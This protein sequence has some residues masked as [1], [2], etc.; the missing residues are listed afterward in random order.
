MP[1]DL[2][3]LIVTA[4]LAVIAVGAAVVA[5]RSV[6]QLRRELNKTA[7]RPIAPSE[8]TEPRP[9]GSEVV[10]YDPVSE[11]PRGLNQ[12]ARLVDGRVVV[13]PTRSQVANAVM[14]QPRVRIAVWA[15]GLAHALR[16]ESR[17]RIRG[18]MR[19]DYRE[20]RRHR[21]RAARVAARNA[22]S[23]ATGVE[24]RTGR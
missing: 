9:S 14:G 20:R 11:P 15:A 22:H 21:N 10:V 1:T 2:I 4:V 12:P 18:L 8:P 17:D 6:R 13:T 5:L 16:P 24:R 23:P 3:V 19:R 7:P